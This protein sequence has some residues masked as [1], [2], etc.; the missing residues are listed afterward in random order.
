MRVMRTAIHIVYVIR[1]WYFNKWILFTYEVRSC[2]L[3]SKTQWQTEQLYRPTTLPPTMHTGVVLSGHR[4]FQ[5]VIWAG[6]LAFTT[7]CGITGFGKI[8]VFFCRKGIGNFYL[9]TCFG[10]LLSASGHT[11]PRTL[12]T[13]HVYR[14][15]NMLGRGDTHYI[16]TKRRFRENCS[17]IVGSR[18]WVH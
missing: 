4:A 12:C 10:V 1:W 16:Y 18:W 2:Y 5:I 14:A 15:V 3:S 9:F 7:S 17:Y 8:L 13:V 6:C 11:R